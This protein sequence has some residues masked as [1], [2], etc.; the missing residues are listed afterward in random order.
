MIVIYSASRNTQG[1]RVMDTRVTTG[2]FPGQHFHPVIQQNA[3]E[4]LPRGVIFS[5]VTQPVSQRLL[6]ST[7]TAMMIASAATAA[8]TSGMIGVLSPV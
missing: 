5:I 8:T 3:P 4:C 2:S 1:F 6:L 7:R